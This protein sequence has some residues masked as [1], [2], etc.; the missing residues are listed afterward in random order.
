MD[1]RIGRLMETAIIVNPYVN[2]SGHQAIAHI[3]IVNNELI[4]WERQGLA[5]G[6]QCALYPRTGRGLRDGILHIDR[7]AVISKHNLHGTAVLIS[8]EQVTP[9]VVKGPAASFIG[10]QLALGLLG[11]HT[12]TCGRFVALSHG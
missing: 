3:I 5:V 10:L 11:D 1:V 4:Q 7:L 12:C 9:R 2:P 6:A 8:G